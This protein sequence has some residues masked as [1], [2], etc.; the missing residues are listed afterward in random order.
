MCKRSSFSLNIKNTNVVFGGLVAYNNGRVINCNLI[1]TNTVNVSIELIVNDY[2]AHIIDLDGSFVGGLVAVNYTKGVIGDCSVTG[3]IATVYSNKSL[4]KSAKV[5][6]FI[7][8]LIYST[9]AKTI[10][11][12]TFGGLVGR[13]EGN[14]SNCG[15]NAEITAKH[16]LL[17]SYLG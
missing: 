17:P 4:V 14:I 10:Q 6:H 16:K 9:S 13:N 7:W 1:G 3:K 15:I 2:K 11:H 8:S 5:T 12:I